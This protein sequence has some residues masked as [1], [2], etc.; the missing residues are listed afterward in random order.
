[1]SNLSRIHDAGILTS[2]RTLLDSFFASISRS[3]NS[4]EPYDSA[5]L[6]FPG[7]AVTDDDRA[8]EL[9]R[10]YLWRRFAWSKEE[11]SS[12]AEASLRYDDGLPPHMYSSFV[13][14]F[15]RFLVAITGGVLL[16]CPMLVMSLNPS[17]TKSQITVSVAVML[18]ASLM[19]LAFRTDNKE[20]LVATA[21]YAAVLVVFVGT[22]S[23]TT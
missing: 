6:G 13:D 3:Q 19:S 10:K 5:L 8:R 21:T 17:T 1:M 15:A 20:T 23:S 18:F 4:Y 2:R 12:S 16:V 7:I 22:S 14:R 11:R 9:L